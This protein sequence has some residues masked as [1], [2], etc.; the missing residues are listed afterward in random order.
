MGIADIRYI[1]P[2]RDL[3]AARIRLNGP[4]EH[5]VECFFP[6]SAHAG[7]YLSLT[8]Q[9]LTGQIKI[10]GIHRFLLVLVCISITKRKMAVNGQ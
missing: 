7:A 6:Q 3:M 5:I 9:R 2:N 1:P 4:L 10:P 8:F